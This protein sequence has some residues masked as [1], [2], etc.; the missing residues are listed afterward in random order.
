MSTITFIYCFVFG[1]EKAVPRRLVVRGNS[2]FSRKE[3][4]LMTRSLSQEPDEIKYA[5]LAI[6]CGH[7]NAFLEGV[8]FNATVLLMIVER[9]VANGGTLHKQLAI[10]VTA[11]GLEHDRPVY[12]C[13][14]LAAE[15][16]GAGNNGHLVYPAKEERAHPQVMRF[17]SQLATELQDCLVAT[18]HTDARVLL[19][20]TCTRYRLPDTFVWGLRSSLDGTGI[21]FQDWRWQSSLPAR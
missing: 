9:T 7:L 1:K 12:Y 19:V 5:G 11:R 18:L 4:F 2:F 14:F 3:I 8:R 20:R 21:S 6:E 16:S 10:H 13:T 17:A 15:V